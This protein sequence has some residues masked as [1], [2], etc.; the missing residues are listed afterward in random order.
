MTGY[1]K[2]VSANLLKT[3][4]SW[5]LVYDEMSCKL[6]ADL[7]TPNPLLL[8]RKVVLKAQRL[9]PDGEAKSV[10][11]LYLL[12]VEVQNVPRTMRSKR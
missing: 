3:T 11:P 4:E 5:Q 7:A 1:L 2:T 9:A 10:T 12:E 8:P 6:K